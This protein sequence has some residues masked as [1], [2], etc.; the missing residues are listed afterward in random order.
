MDIAQIDTNIDVDRILLE[1][2]MLPKYNSQIMLQ[3]PAGV[4]DPF[5]GIGRT[6]EFDYEEKDFCEPTF[7]LSYTNSVIQ[8]LGMFRTRVMKMKMKTCYTYH[9]DKTPRIHVPLVTHEN[10]FF[11]YEDK[12][13]RCPANG[14]AY[15]VDTRKRH[16][17]VNSWIQERIHIVGCVNDLTSS[18]E[19]IL[20]EIKN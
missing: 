12:V 14:M 11:V 19:L 17:F 5:L 6:T 20:R 8:H 15:Y 4:T 1:L 13:V 7:D 10:C 16:T 3:S 18:K 9:Q 2:E